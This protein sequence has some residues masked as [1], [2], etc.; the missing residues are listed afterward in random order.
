MVIK[1]TVVFTEKKSLATFFTVIQLFSR[2]AAVYLD[3]AKNVQEQNLKIQPEHFSWFNFMYKGEQDS[4]IWMP[5]CDSFP[6]F[7]R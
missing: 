5:E 7:S 4:Q 2:L 1:T 3:L 6:R